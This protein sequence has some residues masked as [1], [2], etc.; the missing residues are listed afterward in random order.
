ADRRAYHA[1]FARELYEPRSGPAAQA[2]RAQAGDRAIAHGN[3][4]KGPDDRSAADQDR[5][6]PG[7]SRYRGRPGQKAVRQAA[8]DRRTRG[9]TPDGPGDARGAAI[10][11]SRRTHVRISDSCL[12]Y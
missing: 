11:I 10:M 8:G 6:W 12:V 2:A 5:T 3:G 1:V 9:K 4:A 7:E